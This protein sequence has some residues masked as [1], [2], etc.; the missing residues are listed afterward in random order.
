MAQKE[1][2]ADHKIGCGK[3]ELLA[4]LVRARSTEEIMN[5]MRKINV[6]AAVNAN[7][8]VKPYRLVKNVG[9]Y[10]ALDTPIDW[11]LETPSGFVDADLLHQA[12]ED[13]LIA[14]V[15]SLIAAPTTDWQYCTKDD[16]MD[17]QAVVLRWYGTCHLCWCEYGLKH[18]DQEWE[19]MDTIDWYS[20]LTEAL[21]AARE[22]IEDG[23]AANEIEIMGFTTDGDCRW[24][25]PITFDADGGAWSKDETA[26]EEMGLVH[27]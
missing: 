14:R 7:T 17:V 22:A 25:F 27:W 12:G 8:D 3:D 20:S 10:G 21:S 6:D 2:T 5:T 13:D 23:E 11:V 16:A 18:E 24:D 4:G 9:G 1:A 15:K 19:S 26:R